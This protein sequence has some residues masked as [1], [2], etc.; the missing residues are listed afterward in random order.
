MRYISTNFKLIKKL[1][2]VIVFIFSSICVFSQEI[3]LDRDQYKVSKDLENF[4]FYNSNKKIKINVKGKRIDCE[5]DL[6]IRKKK[7]R[8]RLF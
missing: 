1:S 4:I 6:L 7:T 3:D 5:D 2:L 8:N